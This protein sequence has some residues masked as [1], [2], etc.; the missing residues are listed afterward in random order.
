LL[1]VE[2][3]YT[4]GPYQVPN[5][6]EERLVRFYIPRGSSAPRSVLYMFDGQNI[7]DDEH[8]FSGG[9]HLHQ[10]IEARVLAGK[11]A[12]IIVAIHHGGTS[13]NDEM[14]P[15]ETPRNQGK[16]ELL[17]VWL[18]EE[19]MPRLGRELHLAR[20]PSA[21]SIGGSSMGGLAAL[22]AHL[23]FPESFGK[24]LVMSPS[25]WVG[26]ARFFEWLKVQSLPNASRIYLDS[27]GKEGGG[28]MLLL[29]ERLKAQLLQQGYPPQQLYFYAD[30]EGIHSEREWR[31]RAP[32]AL[33]FLF[34]VPYSPS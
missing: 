25:L 30:P 31:R 24:A 3:I 4:L 16:L 33:D 27:G 12:P 2:P 21:T 26:S 7:F 22:Y 18:R 13:R 28:G 5:L 1:I 20:G 34:D 8:S 23:R 29:A 11:P 17:L 9:W 19:L 6:G 14:S 15:F 10:A 32:Q